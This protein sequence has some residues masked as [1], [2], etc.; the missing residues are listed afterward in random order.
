MIYFVLLFSVNCTN[1][2]NANERA[3]DSLEMFKEKSTTY[4]GKPLK[5]LI[6][7]A[8]SDLI[9]YTYR[10]KCSPYYLR[11][12]FLTYEN[13]VCLGVQLEDFPGNYEYDSTGVWDINEVMSGTVKAIDALSFTDDTLKKVKINRKNE[14]DIIIEER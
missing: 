7:D 11:G 8:N 2:P 4:V 12:I 14:R 5:N 9:S 3:I 1:E 10:H 13:S 6:L